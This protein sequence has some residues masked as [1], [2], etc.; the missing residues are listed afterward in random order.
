MHDHI[1][2]NCVYVNY[3]SAN[4]V[5]KA[6]DMEYDKLADDNKMTFIIISINHRSAR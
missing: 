5:L 6:G 2:P 4:V 1:S 3:K